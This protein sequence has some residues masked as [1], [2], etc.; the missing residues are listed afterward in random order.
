M[1]PI[2]PRTRY[3]AWR[4][5]PSRS[6]SIR[7]ATPKAAPP[8]TTPRTTVDQGGSKPR[9]ANG[10]YVPAMRTKIIEWSSR[11][12]HRHAEGPQSIRWNAALAAYIAERLRA[13]TA[14]ATRAGTDGVISTRDNPAGSEAKK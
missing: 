2:H 11:R 9:R 13:Y 8:Q 10:V 4:M 14:L 12:I 6:E 3:K 7:T 1:A 5:M